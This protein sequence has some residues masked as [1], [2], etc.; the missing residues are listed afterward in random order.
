[1]SQVCEKFGIDIPAYNGD[2]SFRLPVLATYIVEQDG[3]IRYAF[4]SANYTERMES[5]N[6]IER[7]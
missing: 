2:N 4:I 1:M 6:I 7:L 5:S 3:S